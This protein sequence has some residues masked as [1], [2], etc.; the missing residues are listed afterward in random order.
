MR[1]FF[2]DRLMFPIGDRRGRIIAFGGRALSADAKPKYINTGET[3]LFSKGHLLYNF[4]TARAAAIKASTI[5]VAEGYMDVIA[6]VRAGFEAA[7]AP[8][9]T[10]AAVGATD[11]TERTTAGAPGSDDAV[12]SRFRFTGKI[13]GT[14]TRHPAECSAS[15]Y[16]LNQSAGRVWAA[17]G[18]SLGSLQD[19]GCC[20]P[21]GTAIHHSSSSDHA[22][23]SGVVASGR[24]RQCETGRIYQLLPRPIPGRRALG[25]AS[26]LVTAN[27]TSEKE[28]WRVYGRVRR[29][30]T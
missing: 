4:A 13:Q 16:F 9:G 28:R 5:I 18:R 11:H 26:L 25:H 17:S 1:D 10:G 30:N 6:L 2:F 14:G 15:T 8:L 23:R 7:V 27:R 12:I 29:C 21:E 24:S 22:C 20:A 3:T 19:E